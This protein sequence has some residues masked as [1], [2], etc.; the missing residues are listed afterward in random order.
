[1]V[2]GGSS[3]GAAVQRRPLL[4]YIIQLCAGCTDLDRNHMS[5]TRRARDSGQHE[6]DTLAG[7]APGPLPSIRGMATHGG[8]RPTQAEL[9]ELH[10]DSSRIDVAPTF[11][12]PAY[13]VVTE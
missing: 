13:T 7:A 12:T 6:S 10:S 1:M 4:C 11:P 8:N 2:Q 3:R 5:D 9:W